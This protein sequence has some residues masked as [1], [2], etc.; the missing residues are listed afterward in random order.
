MVDWCSCRCCKL[1]WK[2]IK[3]RT[4]SRSHYRSVMQADIHTGRRASVFPQW[5]FR[6]TASHFSS[7]VAETAK[8]LVWHRTDTWIV[9]IQRI[10]LSE[11]TLSNWRWFKI[12][13]RI[14]R[15]ITNLDGSVT[16]TIRDLSLCFNHKIEIYKRKRQVPM[17]QQNT[18]LLRSFNFNIN[19]TVTHYYYYYY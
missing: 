3:R 13:N 8:P 10:S 9:P 6:L 7:K 18:S 5:D 1:L 2:S 12:L 19:I 11:A 16:V 4:V 14:N 17:A 15:K